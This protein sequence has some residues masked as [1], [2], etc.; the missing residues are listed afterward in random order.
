M[1]SGFYVIVGLLAVGA[2]L[3]ILYENTSLFV[4]GSDKNSIKVTERTEEINIITHSSDMKIVPEARNDVKA[5]LNGNGELSLRKQGDT[6]EVEVKQKWYQFFNFNGESD[7]TVYLPADFNQNLRLEV[8]SGNVELKGANSLVLNEVDIEM[9][10]GDVELSNLQTKSFKHDGS[11]GR[12]IIDQLSTE[13][14]NF[15]ISSGDVILTKYSGP[16]KGEMSSGEMKVQMEQLSGD[17]SFDLSSGDVELDLPDDANFTLDTE[18]SSGDIS[19]TFTLKDQMIT[20]NK[21]SG[22]HGSGEHQVNV[23][24]SSG[25]ARVY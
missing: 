5:A 6:I 14:G 11:S 25:N 20:N 15:D 19:T 22:V 23:S 7:V 18:A 8:G 12:L 10:S 3:L 9:S 16:L 24:L 4:G 2:V 21:I 17:V 13:K 1:R